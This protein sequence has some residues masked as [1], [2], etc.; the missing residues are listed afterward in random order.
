MIPRRLNPP[1][2]SPPP[3]S[4]N[5]PLWPSR[6]SRSRR[7]SE[8]GPTVPQRHRR[9]EG[10][11]VPV[12]DGDMTRSMQESQL[13]VPPLRVSPRCPIH[14][15]RAP[16]IRASEPRRLHPS[17]RRNK[18]GNKC[19]PSDRT[20]DRRVSPTASRTTRAPGRDGPCNWTTRRHDPI[21][22]PAEV[23]TGEG[24]LRGPDR[25]RRAFVDRS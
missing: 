12:T 23:M 6:P 13:H 22:G 19:Q 18:R 2:L 20:S 14:D 3:P 5:Q 11:V 8:P 4:L 1:W 21:R 9:E 15:S 25:H 17:R 7:A 16:C 24:A 10:V